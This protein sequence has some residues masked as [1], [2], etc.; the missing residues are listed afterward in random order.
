MVPRRGDSFSRKAGLRKAST[1]ALILSTVALSL[2]VTSCGL[3]TVAYL[4]PP[5][6]L[7]VQ[8]NI[9]SVKN[10]SRNYDDSEGTDQT[11]LGVEV[12]YRVYDSETAAENS[13]AN[14]Q[15]LSDTYTDDPD[16]FVTYAKST[17]KFS[18]LRKKDTSASPLISIDAADE[19]TYNIY[20]DK[21]AI[22][23]DWRLTDENSNVIC[24]VTRTLD[25]NANTS[26]ASFPEKDFQY[27]D[28]DYSGST[29]ASSDSDV[30][31]VFF[32]VSFGVDQNGTVGQNVYSSPDIASSYATY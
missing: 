7:T 14:L 25:S 11:Y 15:S 31:I 1:L 3:P 2:I 12:F 26:S 8:D 19:S 32:A 21:K 23:D 22:S 4:Y 9:L 20:F 30:F 29:I 10:N 13:I 18:R 16:S 17:Y 5:K 27:G 28:S 24:Y 6:D